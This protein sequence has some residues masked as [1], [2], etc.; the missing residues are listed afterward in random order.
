MGNVFDVYLANGDQPESGAYAELS[1][2]AA[3][4]QMQDALDKLRLAEGESI[5]WEVTEYHLC[6]AAAHGAEKGSA[7]PGFMAHRPGL[8]HRLFHVVDEA[9]T[10]PEWR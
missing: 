7:N 6:G 8:Q 10:G 3:P 5:Y 9:L 4:Y 2:P 1:L